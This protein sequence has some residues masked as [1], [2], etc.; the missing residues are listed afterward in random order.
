M[1]QWSQE[2]CQGAWPAFGQQPPGCMQHRV[3]SV[4]DWQV[5]T[6]WKRRSRAS[7]TSWSVDF[8]P[9]L[10]RRQLVALQLQRSCITIADLVLASGMMV[11]IT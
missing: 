6:E 10:L 8:R 9:L 5:R 11:V 7:D 1:S 4:H 2:R 3:C